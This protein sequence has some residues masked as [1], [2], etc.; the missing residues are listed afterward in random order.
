MASEFLPPYAESEEELPGYTPKAEPLTIAMYLFKFGFFFPPFWIL[1]VFIL[2]TPL[3]IP[4]AVVD[5]ISGALIPWLPGKTE[6]ERQQ[7][8][9]EI[10]RAE[11]KWAKRSLYAILSLVF[12]AT[13]VGLSLCFVLGVMT[14]SRRV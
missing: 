12:I 1:G 3:R 8:L 9:L 5:P 10:R 13:I 7:T 4:D 11:L 2:F 14:R 6:A